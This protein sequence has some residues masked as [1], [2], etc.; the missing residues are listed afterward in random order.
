M[1]RERTATGGVRV[2]TRG[3]R[4]DAR[5][6]TDAAVFT[7]GRL[8]VAGNQR[9][10][11]PLLTLAV[12]D[13]LLAIVIIAVFYTASLSVIPLLLAVPPLAAFTVLVQ[14]R[15]RSWWLLLP[16]AFAAWAPVHASGRRH[17]IHRVAAHRRTRVRHR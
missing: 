14:R 12:V 8:P 6:T 11:A 9:P 13:D 10:A 16:L 7:H 5:G 3:S 15:I 17:K 4:A 1:C 2:T